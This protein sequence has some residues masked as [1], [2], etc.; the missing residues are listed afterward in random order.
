MTKMIDIYTKYRPW[1]I[2]WFT[3][4]ILVL[5]TFV[6]AK[7]FET[8]DGR[9]YNGRYYPR[10][11]IIEW[12]TP[13]TM[14]FH[15]Y[16]KKNAVEMSFELIKQGR[17]RI[18]LVHYILT[19]RNEPENL[20]D[21]NSKKYH[22]CRRVLA[23]SHFEEGFMVYKEGVDKD[24]DNTIVSMHPLPAKKGLVQISSP[25]KYLACGLEPERTVAK[26]KHKP[27]KVKQGAIGVGK[28]DTAPF[29]DW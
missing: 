27:Q 9:T 20:Q 16:D 11:D 3:V 21:A 8:F 2:L 17:K 5:P 28:K 19:E 1:I 14:E 23:P 10:I 29:S 13:S 15:V 26:E 24:F 18:M 12:G 22:V 25:T 6:G 4:F 7:E